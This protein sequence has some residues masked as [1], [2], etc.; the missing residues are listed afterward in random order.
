MTFATQLA[1]AFTPIG[2]AY[3][4]PSVSR[5]LSWAQSY[6]TEHC[7][8]EFDLVTGDVAFITPR[9]YRQ[10]L[11]PQFPVAAVTLVQ[12]LLPAAVGG[13]T[14]VTLTNYRFVSETGLIYDTTGEPGT[15]WN[16]GASWPHLPNSLQVTYDHG[17]SVI[18]QQLV[19]VACRLAQ[20]YLEN[21]ALQ[22]Q[23]RTGDMEARYAGS[24]GVVLTQLDL[25][26]LD[27]YLDIGIA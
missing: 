12:G 18:P 4:A 8:R 19:D 20:Q 1:A 26:I 15:T 10:A 13:L 22:M 2:G 7:G 3:D 27:R 24:V 16:L 11:L 5:A 6:V 9:A 25:R 23:R 21:P 14:W 17:Y